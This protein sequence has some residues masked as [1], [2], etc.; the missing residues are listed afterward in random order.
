GIPVTRS[1]REILQVNYVGVRHLV[2]QLLPVLRDGGTVGIVASN[3]ARGWEQRLPTVLEILDLADPDEAMQ[4]FDTH[5][6]E[7]SDGYRLSK[8]LLVAWVARIAPS[9][10]TGRRIRINCTAPGVTDTALVEETKQYVPDGFFDTY[11][12]PLFDRA[13]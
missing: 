10:A 11:P 2:E 5:T 9:L 1:A 13:A 7:V 8:Q 3:V 6:D 12:Y 4:W